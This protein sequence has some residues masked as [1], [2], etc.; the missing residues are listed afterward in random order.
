[1]TGLEV[2]GAGAVAKVG[3][4]AAPSV[5]KFIKEIK[6]YPNDD[7]IKKDILVILSELET[8]DAEEKEQSRDRIQQIATWLAEVA[9]LQ[10]EWSMQTGLLE[11]YSQTRKNKIKATEK[12]AKAMKKAAV[13]ASAQARVARACGTKPKKQTSHGSTSPSQVSIPD[14]MKISKSQGFVSLNQA[15]QFFGEWAN[16]YNPTVDPSEISTTS[17]ATTGS[18]SSRAS[19]QA[20]TGGVNYNL[21]DTSDSASFMSTKSGFDGKLWRNGLGGTDVY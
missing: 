4:A 17:P 2:L 8:M 3:I 13:T 1:M 5:W 21:K 15:V 20:T 12:D 9:P 14:M 7:Q 6:L 18:D 10:E 11:K 16:E 19:R